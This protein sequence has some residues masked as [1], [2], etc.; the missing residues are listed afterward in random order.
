MTEPATQ[1]STK[2]YLRL[3]TLIGVIVPR[4][5]R[6]DWRQE[7]EAELRY[8]EMSLAEWDKIKAT[9]GRFWLWL[10]RTVELREPRFFAAL[11]AADVSRGFQPTDRRSLGTRRVSDG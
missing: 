10:R 9:R 11:A 7:W 6:V 5:L 3:I 1:R 2:P 4:R 8:R